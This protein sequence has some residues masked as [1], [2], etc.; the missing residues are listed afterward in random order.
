MKPIEQMAP[1]ELAEWALHPDVCSTEL[2]RQLARSLLASIAVIE[3]CER[4]VA[5]DGTGRGGGLSREVRE[6]IAKAQRP[7]S[8][9]EA[10]S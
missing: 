3:A 7:A 2:T 6:A 8:A 10:T 5:K 1:R 9:L 4:Q